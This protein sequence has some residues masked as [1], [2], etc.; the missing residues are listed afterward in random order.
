MANA[1]RDENSIP[2][3]LGVSNADGTTPI[4][5]YADPTTHRLL[6]DVGSGGG[7]LTW[8]DVTGTIDG[9]NVTFTIAVS[10]GSGIILYLARQPQMDTLDYSV[11]GST[12]TYTYAPDASLSGQPH[13][14]GVIS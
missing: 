14:A 5:V 10:P 4:R 1:S 6:V 2:T 8:Y 11:S 13:K 12:I 9:S 3:L 7:T